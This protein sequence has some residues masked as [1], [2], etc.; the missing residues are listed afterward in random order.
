MSALR[1][2]IKKL[3]R[4]AVAVGHAPVRAVAPRSSCVRVLTYHG[5][6]DPGR[7]PFRVAATAFTEQMRC[8]ADA[9]LAL[10]LSDLARYLKS[11]LEPPPGSVVVTIDDG[12]ACLA[13]VALPILSRFEI[14]AVAFV[15]A[16]LIGL[17]GY[18]DWQRLRD[19]RD[20]GITIG[21]HGLS[22]CSLG[23]LSI[24]QAA[25]EAGESKERLEQEL[26]QSVDAFA[27]PFGAFPD[28]NA[29]TAAVLRRCD[30]A[31]GFTSQHGAVRHGANPIELPRVKVEGGDSSRL[32]QRLVHG[33]LDPWRLVD[34]TLWGLQAR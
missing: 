31:W 16:G 8:L 15:S 18:L 23:R 27:Y 21:S 12:L 25:R 33:A 17:G 24:P 14:P 32:F 19:V 20:A 6:G 26:G 1:W 7:D 29:A 11:E 22:H 34:R 30:Y 4:R 9:G 28:F 10:S 5:F 3:A 2:H 13:S